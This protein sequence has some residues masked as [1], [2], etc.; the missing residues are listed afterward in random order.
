M[1]KQKEE[2]TK[3]FHA[4]WDHFTPEPGKQKEMFCRVCKEKMDVQ[5]NVNGPTGWAEAMGKGKH[6]HDT[7]SCPF[8]QEDWHNQVRVLL[9]RIQKETSRTIAKMLKKEAK[10]V[11][12][13]RKTTL[14][15]CWGGSFL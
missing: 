7:F 9:E 8:A 14:K 15:R 12:E 10:Q 3:H 6:A 13:T 5:R 2:K 1:S 11:L 4:G